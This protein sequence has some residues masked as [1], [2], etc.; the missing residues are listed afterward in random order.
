MSEPLTK[1][2]V[3][4]SETRSFMK[5]SG[6]FWTRMLCAIALAAIAVFAF[7]SCNNKLPDDPTLTGTVSISGTAQ[8]GETLSANTASL[9]GDGTISYQY[10]RGTTNIGSNSSTYTVV[11]ADVDS[12]ITVT[13]TRVGYVGSVTSSPTGKV[14]AGVTPTPPSPPPTP[15]PTPQ[16][17]QN[18]TSFT[19]QGEFGDGKI[20][21]LSNAESYSR[22]SSIGR[23]SNI[24]RNA[25]SAPG[26]Y[27]ISG[28]LQDGDIIFR[29]SGTYDP[30]TRNYTASAASSMIRFSINGAF[31]EAGESLGSTATVLTRTQ[32]TDTWTGQ[33]FAI[34]ETVATFNPAATD[35][36]DE[37]DTNGIPAFARGWWSYRDEDDGYVYE[38]K[39]L[40]SEWALLNDEKVTNPDGSINYY[41]SAGSVIEVTAGSGYWDIIVGFPHYQPTKDLAEQAAAAFLSS[42]NLS[43]TKLDNNPWA[44]NWWYHGDDYTQFQY[45]SGGYFVS[46]YGMPNNPGYPG[47][48]GNNIN[49]S[50]SAGLGG[51]GGQNGE[52]GVELLNEI[53]Q[54]INTLFSQNKNL[55]ERRTAIAQFLVTKGITNISMVNT[56]PALDNPY[57]FYHEE[58]EIIIFGGNF[59]EADWNKILQW[60]NTNA[61][62]KYLIN[63]NVPPTTVY[64]K[65][66]AKFESNNSVLLLYAYCT[67][68]G[69]DWQYEWN[70]VAGARA[71]TSL[72]LEAY[73]AFA[74]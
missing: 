49:R 40:L 61:L 52:G 5:N 15:T 63:A 32:G 14:I 56:P 10:R 13:V 67:Q 74:R 30:I 64:F 54:L 58:M 12:N 59:N 51:G 20:F 3:D 31:S 7:S 25:N 70:S 69:F 36:T 55:G 42:K 4:H 45:D 11:D 33:S 66:R 62:E 68:N 2:S 1:R 38:G 53:F 48:L 22:A 57:Y 16:T 35:N 6:K 73:M 8:V 41:Q 17:P 29:L 9:N 47:Y 18:P 34:A 21:K 72:D 19:V 46:H 44:E 37:P 43:A 23:N 27:A 65:T 26:T 50:A 60:Y 39:M 28:E 24:G 71:A